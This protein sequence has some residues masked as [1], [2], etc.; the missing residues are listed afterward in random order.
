MTET[1]ETFNHEL[2]GDL[3]N[4]FKYPSNEIRIKMQK[5]LEVVLN[6]KSQNRA[7]TLSKSQNKFIKECVNMLRNITSLEK[8]FEFNQNERFKMIQ[9]TIS[10][11]LFLGETQNKQAHGFGVI[12]TNKNLLIEGRFSSGII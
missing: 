7:V 10:G 11:D 4:L 6:L 12:L 2:N 5:K 3:I 1:P 8:G 9:L